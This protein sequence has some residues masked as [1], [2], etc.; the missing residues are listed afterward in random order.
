MRTW[1]NH[2]IQT[3]LRSK[4]WPISPIGIGYDATTFRYVIIESRN[5]LKVD[6]ADSKS[7]LTIDS[8]SRASDSP[9]HAYN[10]NRFIVGTTKAPQLA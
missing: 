2:V 7:G 6:S 1:L 8:E 9:V 5:G 4:S 3:A 10:L